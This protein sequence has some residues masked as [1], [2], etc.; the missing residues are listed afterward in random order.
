MPWG[1]SGQSIKL[2]CSFN[3]LVNDC[4]V[5]VAKLFAAELLARAPLLATLLPPS[6]IPLRLSLASFLRLDFADFLDRASSMAAARAPR[7]AERTAASLCLASCRCKAIRL[8]PRPS[9]LP[10][11]SSTLK[12][13]R[14]CSGRFSCAWSQSSSV[15]STWRSCCAAW[16]K[17]CWKLT[18][19]GSTA[20]GWLAAAPSAPPPGAL[21]ASVPLAAPPSLT[22]PSGWLAA[23]PAA[24]G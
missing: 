7:T 22:L 15:I 19:I 13:M 23:V 21:D 17:A 2:V 20:P 12:P 24:C 8:R 14:R 3:G 5:I 1:T 9:L 18:G 6:G 4:E 16:V 10:R 11:A